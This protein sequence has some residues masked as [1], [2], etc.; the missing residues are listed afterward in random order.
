MKKIISCIDTITNKMDKQLSVPHPT[1]MSPKDLHKLRTFK[2]LRDD[3]VEITR[4]YRIELK[5]NR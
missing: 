5:Y 1:I 3:L 4:V 2:H